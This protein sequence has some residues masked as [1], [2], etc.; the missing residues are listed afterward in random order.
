LLAIHAIW[1]LDHRLHLWAEDAA[2]FEAHRRRTARRTAKTPPHPWAAS[3]DGVARAIE[4]ATA[5]DV[6]LVGDAQPG[7]LALWLPG[8]RANPRPSP[9]IVAPPH[10]G[11]APAVCRRGRD[12]LR[13][14]LL[15]LPMPDPRP[16]GAEWVDAYRHWARPR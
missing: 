13:V 15:E 16:G 8:D 7:R 2:A 1:A 11:A 6:D 14:A 3:A 12:V 10:G 5:G 9:R 4:A